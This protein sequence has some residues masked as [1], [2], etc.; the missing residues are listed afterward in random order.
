MR[1]VLYFHHYLPALL[2]SCL[3]TGGMGAFILSFLKNRQLRIG[4]LIA[5]V[6]ICF[7]SFY[8]QLDLA[9]GTEEYDT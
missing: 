2:F 7:K 4:C 8:E 9:Y 1:R 5:V 6:A 3:V